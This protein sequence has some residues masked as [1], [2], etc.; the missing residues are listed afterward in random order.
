LRRRR[1]TVMIV[2][3]MNGP[4]VAR[5]AR[6][7]ILAPLTVAVGVLAACATS[8]HVGARDSFARA[9]RCAP[10]GISVVPRPD[11]K[12]P[13]SAEPSSPDEDAGPGS[14]G[15][16][17]QRRNLDRRISEA[18]EADCEMFEVTGCGQRRLFC[19]RHPF[20]RDST[21]VLVMRADTVDCQPRPEP[22][23]EKQ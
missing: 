13:S 7:A 23:I 6:L 14:L 5:W 22:V 21:G 11:Y 8:L 1:A 16:W 10:D 19:C 3:G 17:Q 15:F 18:P 2:S 4:R 20:A 12:S 9:A